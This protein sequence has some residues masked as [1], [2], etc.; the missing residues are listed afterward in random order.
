MD[1]HF[2]IN[3]Y[4]IFLVKDCKGIT[5]TNTKEEIEKRNGGEGRQKLNFYLS[6]IPIWILRSSVSIPRQNPYE[7]SMFRS[8]FD[9]AGIK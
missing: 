6:A 9:G 1:Y 7:Y 5:H 3:R 4:A 8:C 2:I